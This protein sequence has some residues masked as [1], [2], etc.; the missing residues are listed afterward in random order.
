MRCLFLASKLMISSK[1]IWPKLAGMSCW[2]VQDDK[3]TIISRLPTNMP[4]VHPYFL[5]PPAFII[6][7]ISNIKTHMSLLYR[8]SRRPL[9]AAM[10]CIAWVH[11]SFYFSLGWP[12]IPPTDST[13]VY[14]IE[15]RSQ[16]VQTP[17]HRSRQSTDALLVEE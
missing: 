2:S 16:A 3:V 12:F 15:S 4:N 17:H 11:A 5:I 1:D 6:I 7:C 14:R 13:V 10:C 8:Y 9:E